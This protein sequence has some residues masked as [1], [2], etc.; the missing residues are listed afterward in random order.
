MFRPFVFIGIGAM[1]A[2][3]ALLYSLSAANFC[4]AFAALITL[5]FIS[6]KK[7]KLNKG[8]VIALIFVMLAVRFI[9]ISA[10]VQ[11][12]TESLHGKTADLQAEIIDID[13][14][15]DNFASLSLRVI[16]CELEEAKN[17]KLK[18]T[19]MTNADVLPGD[20]ISAKVIFSQPDDKFKSANF[21]DGYYYSADISKIYN[22][23]PAKLSLWRTVY[24]V[25][26]AVKAAIDSAGADEKSAVL[27]ALIIGDSSAISPEIS[28]RVRNSGVSHMLVV[29]GMHLGILVGVIMNLM[30]KRTKTV[31][32]VI[33]GSISAVI[34]LTVCLFHVSILR[35]SIAY[36]VMLSARLFKRDSDPLSALGFGVAVA[37][38]LTPYIFYDVSFLLSVAAT[39]AVIYPA[40]L[41][42]D[43]VRFKRF[44]K[45][46]KVFRYC[47]DIL[48]ISVCSIFCT[49]PIVVN[50][51]GYVALAA[52]LTNLAVSLA[53]SWALVTGVFAV[54]VFFLPF[55]KFIC[56]P[57]FFMA[58]GCVKFFIDAVEFIGKDG[59]GVVFV[60][61]DKNIY[62]FLVAAAFILIV[63]ILSN[64][65]K[66]RKEKYC[67]E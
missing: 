38:M 21:A 11:Y 59:F 18:A 10:T 17:I 51:F 34:I 19:Q 61:R 40:R 47:Y 42:I 32:A 37:V 9:S 67:A 28:E 26:T 13:Y 3:F 31:T 24:N 66:Q 63:K 20:I 6:F 44:G 60:E 49:L 12:K 58:R 39:F 45:L 27:K 23:K 25:R 30:K 48:I 65:I 22:K 36:I 16:D 8:V 46:G 52:P 57:F 2:S 1:A 14:N 33:V 5:V 50:C 4:L 54:L 35:A 56:L 53:M 43:I 15:S 62:C 29:S 7:E 41:L 55:G 64:Y